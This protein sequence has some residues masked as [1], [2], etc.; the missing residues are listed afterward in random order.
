MR[1]VILPAATCSVIKPY[2]PQYDT[3]NFVNTGEFFDTHPGVVPWVTRY[4]QTALD[5]S[6]I[7][8]WERDKNGRM[9]NVTKR[10]I[11]RKELIEAQEQLAKLQEEQ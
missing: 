3:S 9:V 11:Y 6:L 7:E 8:S 5:G 4:E 1:E 2:E 10:D